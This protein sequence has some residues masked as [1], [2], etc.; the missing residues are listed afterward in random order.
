MHTLLGPLGSFL[1]QFGLVF[2]L[3]GLLAQKSLS[4]AIFGQTFAFVMLNKV[5][6]SQYF[7]WYLFLL[8]IILV[9]SRLVTKEKWRTGLM[10]LILWVASQVS[11]FS[12]CLCIMIHLMFNKKG[13]WLF[14]A[15]QLEHLGRPT[16][17]QLW[18]ASSFMY[19][20]NAW[21]LAQFIQNHI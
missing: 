14:F 19:I 1:P 5:C 9:E 21:I 18:F 2:L 7:M 3:G 13:L 20:S 16:F 12:S 10:C 4:L 11:L 17:R 6:T 8:P 15:Y